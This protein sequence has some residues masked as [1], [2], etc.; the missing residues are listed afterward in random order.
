V[1]ANTELRRQL[2]E[3]LPIDIEYAPLNLCT[4]N[5]AMIASLGYYQSEHT[6]PDNLYNME[7]DTSLS[8]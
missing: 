5:A 4:D 2:K 1:A 7:I 3:R 6:R 8:M